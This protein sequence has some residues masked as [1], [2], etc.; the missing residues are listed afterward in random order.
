VA[1]A[2]RSLEAHDYRSAAARAEA[3]LVQTPGDPD[4]ERLLGEARAALRRGEAAARDLRQVLD[5]GDADRA[6]QA[7]GRL[8]DMDPR[9]PELP[10]LTLRVNQLLKEQAVAAQRALD[11][12]RQQPPIV[13]PRTASPPATPAPPTPAPPTPA[14]AT[15]A[16]VVPSIALTPAQVEAARKDIRGVLQEYQTAV[17][18]RNAEYLRRL[19]PGLDYE[20][21]RTT[22]AAVAG[23]DVKI[24]VKDVSVSGDTA[25]AQCLVT[26]TPN[27]RPAGKL[28]PV[29]TLFRLKR[30]GAVWIIE[31]VLR[32]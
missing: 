8:M 25:A 19:A 27:P 10:R 28:K 15:A 18:T 12:A 32:R 13:P 11:Q 16:P 30:V 9:N 20:T 31:E 21:L 29:P 4:A 2:R 23:M 3:A 7:L 5:S 26:Y 22:F 6:S 17:E 1:E 14:P 24:D